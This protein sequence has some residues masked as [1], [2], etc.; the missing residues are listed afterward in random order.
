MSRQDVVGDALMVVFQRS[1]FVGGPVA[2][3][4]ILQ[5]VPSQPSQQ[6]WSVNEP[7]HVIVAHKQE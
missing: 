3:D 4:N 6:V 7:S 1:V 2:I 5:H